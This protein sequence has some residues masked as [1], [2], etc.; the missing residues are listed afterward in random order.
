MKSENSKKIL[1][2]QEKIV[3]EKKWD[4]VNETLP[5]IRKNRNGR[6]TSVR[7]SVDEFMNIRGKGKN[8]P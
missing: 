6:G 7:D 5:L 8:I 4:K 1:E 2:K 3:V